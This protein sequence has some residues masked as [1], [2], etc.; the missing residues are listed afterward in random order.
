MSSLKSLGI[1]RSIS[2]ELRKSNPK[3]KPISQTSAYVF[4]TNEYRCHQVTEKRTCKGENELKTIAQTYLCYLQST[5]KNKELLHQYHSH[6]ERS[7]EETAGIVGFKLPEAG[8]N[9]NL[10]QT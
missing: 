5:R 4:L 3:M 10:E 6:G 1:L 7:V 2:H 9:S 8:K